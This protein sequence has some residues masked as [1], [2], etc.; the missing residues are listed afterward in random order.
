MPAPSEHNNR[1]IEYLSGLAEREDRGALAA[2]RRGVGK[3]PGTA[4]ETFPIMVPW[5]HTLRRYQADIY[6]TVGALFA[7]H[8]SNTPRG[9]LGDTFAQIR[10]AR[11]GEAGSLERRFVA[12]LKAH[13]DDAHNHLR[14]AVGLAR[15]DDVPVNWA[16]LLADLTAW[17][18]PARYI[19]QQWAAGYWGRS[20]QTEH[21]QSDALQTEG[22][23]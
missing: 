7:L 20:G 12:L 19:Q 6:F 10:A 11:G 13:R 5:T 14:H 15:S 23:Q 1:F 4:P 18:H 3:A 21:D 8:P 22:K 9:N 17:D 16:Q 2:L